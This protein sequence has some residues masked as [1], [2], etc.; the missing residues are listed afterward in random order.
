MLTTCSRCLAG[1]NKNIPL[2]KSQMLN[3]VVKI[4]KKS[5]RYLAKE[6]LENIIFQATSKF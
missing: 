6:N 5:G 3:F 2:I 4:G 1:N